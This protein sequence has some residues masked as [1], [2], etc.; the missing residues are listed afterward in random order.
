MFSL[1]PS[2]KKEGEDMFIS[3]AGGGRHIKHNIS[4]HK[5]KYLIFIFKSFFLR[6]LRY[7]QSGFLALVLFWLAVINDLEV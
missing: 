5:K 1:G 6:K 2:P 7:V 4:P 3:A